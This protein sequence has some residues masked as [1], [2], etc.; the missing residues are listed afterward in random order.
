VLLHPPASGVPASGVPVSGVP[1]SAVPA[2]AAPQDVTGRVVTRYPKG[3][4]CALSPALFLAWT[5]T[6]VPLGIRDED[7]PIHLFQLIE[8]VGGGNVPLSFKWNKWVGLAN[9][10]IATGA[11]VIVHAQSSLGQRAQTRPFGYL[12]VTNPQTAPCSN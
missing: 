3:C 9:A 1:V 11:S 7:E 10:S 2:S 8:I 4:V 6:C 5:T 12:S